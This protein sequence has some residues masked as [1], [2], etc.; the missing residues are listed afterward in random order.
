MQYC[1]ETAINEFND[2][3]PEPVGPK[4]SM[5]V[6]PFKPFGQSGKGLG[7]A[8]SIMSK[9]GYR[10]VCSLWDKC[11]YGRIGRI[12]VFGRASIM[13]RIQHESSL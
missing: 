5:P 1:I 12:D 7:V 10:W 6:A 9:M 4:F 11:G 2:Q 13:H 8:A 3:E